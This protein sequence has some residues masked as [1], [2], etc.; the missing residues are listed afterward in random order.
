VGA[1]PCRARFGYWIERVRAGEDVLVTRRGTPMI[2]LTSALASVASRPND[3]VPPPPVDDV[4]PAHLFPSPA[5][6]A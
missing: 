4:S 3:S 6:A 5:D 1:D 2:R